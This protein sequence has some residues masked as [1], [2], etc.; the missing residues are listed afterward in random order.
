M[1]GGA[2]QAAV[3][4]VTKSWPRLSDFTF[5][6]MHWRRKWQP[7]PVFFPRESQGWGSL[8]GCHLWGHTGSDTT[9][10]TQQQQQQSSRNVICLSL[11]A[12]N[13]QGQKVISPC[14]CPW[15]IYLPPAFQMSRN[16]ISPE[17][18]NSDF[19][20]DKN[21]QDLLPQMQTFS[22]L[23]PLVSFSLFYFSFSTQ[24][25]SFFPSLLFLPSF[26]FFFFFFPSLVT[27]IAAMT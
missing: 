5:T 13:R 8:V 10:A 16:P 2:W 4:R 1:D 19:I 25:L 21:L 26:F 9:E 6:F 18:S 17:N 15:I 20:F 23:L 27:E 12:G 3:H 7:T 24:Y 22:P 14:R 11:E